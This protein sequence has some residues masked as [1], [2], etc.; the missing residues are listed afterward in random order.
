MMVSEVDDMESEM[1]EV[2]REST[3]NTSIKS[4]VND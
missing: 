2:I 4:A 3:F 1:E